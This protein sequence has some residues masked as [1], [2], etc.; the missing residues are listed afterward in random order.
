MAQDGKNSL[1]FQ[2][3]TAWI[4]ADLTPFISGVVS[5]SKKELSEYG[6]WKKVNG[7]DFSDT[8]YRKRCA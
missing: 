2:T 1:F 7:R 3:S 8:E 4:S 6:Q 5:S